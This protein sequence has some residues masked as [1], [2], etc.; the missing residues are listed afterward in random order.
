[1]ITF[2]D[3]VGKRPDGY[4]LDRIDNSKG[5]EPGNVRWV[6]TSTQQ[7]NRRDTVKVLYQGVEYTK[8][9]LAKHLKIPYSTLLYRLK[10][11]MLDGHH[12]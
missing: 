5:Y 9:E 10:M 4:S 8:I 12:R 3:H 2:V 1:M 6:D 11:G 7:N